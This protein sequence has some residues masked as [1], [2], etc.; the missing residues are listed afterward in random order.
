ML[1]IEIKLNGEIIAEAAIQ[2]L[3]E[4]AEVSDYNVR[5]NEFPSEKLGIPIDR[6]TFGIK[7]HRRAQTTWALVAKVAAAI[8]GQMVER[9]EALD[10]QGAIWNQTHRD[11]K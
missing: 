5:W 1:T 3:S 7:R 10:G 8:I 2:N 11:Y 6:G 9:G 4:L